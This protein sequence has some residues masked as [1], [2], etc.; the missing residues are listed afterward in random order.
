MIVYSQ[1]QASDI[2]EVVIRIRD[3]ATIKKFERLCFDK[4]FLS[5][6]RK[7]DWEEFKYSAVPKQLVDIVHIGHGK[8]KKVRTIDIDISAPRKDQFTLCYIIYFATGKTSASY[9]KNPLGFIVQ[10]P[11]FRDRVLDTKLRIKKPKGIFIPGSIDLLND[12][13]PT[14]CDKANNE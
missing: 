5:F 8:Y 6:I 2:E 13:K 1:N 9:K 4:Q 10:T 14:S 7:K 12:S 3:L 11:E